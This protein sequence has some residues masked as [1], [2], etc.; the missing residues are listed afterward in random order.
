MTSAIASTKAVELRT[1]LVQL[2][3]DWESYFGVAPS[4]T[5]AISELDGALLV[6][7]NEDSYCSHG[8]LRTAV[9]MDTD[10]ISNGIRYQVTANRSSGR[11]DLRY[12]GEPKNREEALWMGSFDLDSTLLKKRGSSQ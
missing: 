9:S 11:R 1:R 10:L 2:S 3:L 7:M 5:P 4:I 8:Q 6:G 12:E